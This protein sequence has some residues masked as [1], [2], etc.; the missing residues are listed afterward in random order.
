[1]FSL[2]DKGLSVERVNHIAGCLRLMLGEAVRA[3]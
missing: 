3:A 1:M 2:R